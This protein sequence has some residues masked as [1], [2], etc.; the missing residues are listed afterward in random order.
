MKKKKA[1]NGFPVLMERAGKMIRAA[2]VET[3][4]GRTVVRL[5]IAL[6]EAEG[7]SLFDGL[8]RSLCPGQAVRF[9][10]PV[11]CRASLRAAGY[12]V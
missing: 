5:R 10:P 9:I 6:S 2:D 1:A 4:R 7:I 12:K 3:L 11:E 8:A